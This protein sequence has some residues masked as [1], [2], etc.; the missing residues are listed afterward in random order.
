MELAMN[1]SKSIK[2]AI[3]CGVL[4]LS[5]IT[6]GW[7]L[8]ARPLNGH[9]SYVSV[10]ARRMLQTGDWVVPVYNGEVRIQKPPLNYWLV[11]LTAK[12]TG[13]I[14]DFTVRVPSVILALLSTVAILYFINRCLGF[15]AAVLSA[16]IWSTS[17]GFV[18]Y[19]R[20]ARPEMSLTCFVT[21]AFLAFYSALE[22]AQ[23]KRQIAY[24]LIF[25]ASFAIAMLAKGPA[26]LPLILV[27]LFLYFLIFRQWKSLPKLLPITGVIIFLLI[28]L[29]WPIL[30]A[31]RL[32]ETAGGEINTIGF[33][34]REFFNRYFGGL[35]GSSKPLHY[36]LHVMLQFIL[37]WSVF[38]P[39]ALAAPFYKVWGEKQKTMLFLWFW[40]VG[41]V[42]VM[43]LSSGKRMHY[44]MPAMPAMAI[45]VGILFD[46]L[47]FARLAYSPRFAQNV[48]LFHLGI[49]LA[50]AIG[51]PAYAVIQKQY[52]V[53][54]ETIIIS[55]LTLIIGSV[56]AAL[57]ARNK[58]ALG[59]AAIFVGYCALFMPAFNSLTETKGRSYYVS[60]FAQ[61]VASRIHQS[62]NLVA[63]KDV[64]SV[65]VHYFGK[66][67]PVMQDLSQTFERYRTG[68]WIVATG[69]FAGRLMNDGRFAIAWR[70]PD[71]R[72]DEGK[73][74]QGALF[75]R[76]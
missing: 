53:F 66:D 20:S 67:V 72:L 3:V 28:V 73:I 56:I 51:V 45:L 39:M 14:D 48:L 13:H 1:N 33:W 49:L 12:I 23:R 4:L 47:V 74:I 55:L 42:A 63:Y 43:S 64:S 54:R 57:F 69:D 32:A 16:L 71:A 40:F 50:G 5:L 26:P 9:E 17:I 11:A 24:L 22:T 6:A 35:G 29:P 19:G 44:I 62:E 36:Y 59:C 76:P 7:K 68:S 37:P 61:S 70:C 25:W 41:G 58:P 75:H 18:R 8:G 30:V 10:T 38:L 46:D 2:A 60:K 15:R 31:N 21:I 65:F 27:P 52:V 34:K